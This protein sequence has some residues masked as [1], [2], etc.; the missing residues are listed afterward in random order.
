MPDTDPPRLPDMHH[1]F[2]SSRD[3]VRRTLLAVMSTLRGVPCPGVDAAAVEL[4]LAEALNNV[5]EHACGSMAGR[6]I[7]L[8]IW[9]APDGL[10]FR[11]S[12]N[13]QPMVCDPA[14][15]F[16]LPRPASLPEGGF[17]WPIIRG[18]TRDLWYRHAD[19]CNMLSFRVPVRSEPLAHAC[20][21]GAA[22]LQSASG[23]GH[24]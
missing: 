15:S 6:V 21:A 18:L 22:G 4:V 20:H 5:V 16:P 9:I 3:A 24:S 2:P 1:I 7:G 17:G 8:E 14:A 13:G 10:A 12:D 23:P 19:G 11:V